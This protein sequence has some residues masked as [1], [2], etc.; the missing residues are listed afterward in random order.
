M[1]ASLLSRRAAW[2]LGV[3]NCK[4]FLPAVSESG[5]LQQIAG[6]NS[7]P[8][9]RNLKDPYIPDKSSEKTPAWQKTEKYDRKVFAKYGRASGL[10]PAM[11]WPS[12]AQLKELIAEEKEWQPPLEVLLERIAVKEKEKAA[13]RLAREQLIATNMA[14]MPKM[15]ADWKRDKQEAKKK[16][17]EDKAK[18]E[19]LLA[20]A[21]ERFGYALHHRSEKFKEIVAELEKEEKKKKK[22]LKRKQKEEERGLALSA[23]APA[24]AAA[25]TATATAT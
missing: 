17:K 12:P 24:P 6:Y 3:S 23:P 9:W 20:E 18:K 25:T 21:R 16:L 13:K 15:I 4:S 11:L 14:K 7:K 22:L 5:V 2:L 8:F 10:D 1:A 19:Q